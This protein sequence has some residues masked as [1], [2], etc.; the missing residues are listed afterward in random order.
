MLQ[1]AFRQNTKEN[2]LIRRVLVFALLF[3]ALHVSLHDLDT[4]DGGLGEH[5]T[6]H[7]C[8]LNHVPVAF[9]PQPSLLISPQFLNCLSVVVKIV[10]LPFVQFQ[11]QWTRAPPL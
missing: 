2:L 6:C 8:R 3:A 9:L 7:V 4:I 11:T 5:D 1:K 10:F